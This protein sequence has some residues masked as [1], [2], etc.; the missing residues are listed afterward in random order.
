ML[1]NCP[2]CGTRQAKSVKTIKISQTIQDHTLTHE[3]DAIYE[4]P[5]CK[6][7]FNSN[8]GASKTVHPESVQPTF[9]HLIDRLSNVQLG[10]IENL[11]KLRRNLDLLESERPSVLFDLETLRKNSEYKADGLE[12]DVNKLREEIRDLKEVL[13]LKKQSD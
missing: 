5:K 2:N 7:T 4:C 13:G 3:V 8:L 10:L 6:S 11:E 9:L 1:V 12:E